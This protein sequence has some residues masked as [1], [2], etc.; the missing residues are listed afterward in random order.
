MYAARVSGGKTATCT[1]T[2]AHFWKGS[3]FWGVNGRDH[4]LEASSFGSHT[5]EF[6]S[7]QCGTYYMRIILYYNVKSTRAACFGDRESWMINHI[8]IVIAVWATIIN[9]WWM[10]PI[11]IFALAGEQQRQMHWRH[12]CGHWSRS[13]EQKHTREQPSTLLLLDVRLKNVKCSANCSE[14]N[15]YFIPSCG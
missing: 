15:L 5:D 3:L 13:A 7:F 12:A 14:E 11:N 1:Y 9:S 6:S 2:H 10:L 8:Y 4:P